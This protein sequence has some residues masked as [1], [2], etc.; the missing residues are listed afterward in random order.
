MST[1]MPTLRAA[2]GAA[3]LL[4]LAPLAAH[5]QAYPPCPG[6]SLRAARPILALAPVAP[7]SATR[8]LRDLLASASTESS[9][10][11]MPIHER[12]ATDNLARRNLDPMV[13]QAYFGSA[14]P[15][16]IRLPDSLKGFLGLDQTKGMVAPGSGTRPGGLDGAPPGVP[17]ALGVDA[18]GNTCLRP[19]TGADW[20]LDNRTHQIARAWDPKGF[21]DVGLL[22]RFN[23]DTSPH[24]DFCTLTRIAKGFAVTAAHCVIDST[25]GAAIAT[26]DY[27]AAARR[28]LV[29]TPRLDGTALD[30]PGCFDHPQSCGYFVSRPLGRA[31]LRKGTV[32]PVDSPAPVPDVALLAVAFDPAAP[33]VITSVVAQQAAGRLTIAGYG[34]TDA[35]PV[36]NWGDLLVGWQQS[37]TSV[38]DQEL[39][40]SVDVADGR[41]GVCTGDSGGPVYLGDFAGLPGESKRLGGVVSTRAQPGAGDAPSDT[42]TRSGNNT[43]ARID[44][45][46]AWICPAGKG[47]IAGCPVV[48]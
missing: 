45:E 36:N 26:R 14:D 5:A 31:T 11:A 42:C 7:A 48:H 3:L 1:F 24:Y 41:A 28:S 16:T 27:A 13:Y 34:H 43:A 33:S 35:T 21:R 17:V 10:R 47:S 18:A 6:T 23:P 39:V 2:L 38:D 30:I 40:W 22:V 25:A 20:T 37:A 19:A 29:L 32:W 46:L 4:A 8:S 44:T 15:A 9:L 12:L